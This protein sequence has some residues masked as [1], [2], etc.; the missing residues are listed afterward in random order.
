MSLATRMRPSA[1]TMAPEVTET[2]MAALLDLMRK[3]RLEGRHLEIGTAAGGTLKSLMQAY[4][5]GARPPF[6]VIDPMTYFPNQMETVHQNLRQAGIDPSCVEFRIGA[7]A[8]LLPAA[9][10]AGDRFDFVFI[11]G[12]HKAGYVIRDLGWGSLVRTGGV[13]C[14]HDHSEGHPGVTW[15]A[16]RFLRRNRGVYEK[17]AL[18]QSLLVIRKVR[19]SVG[20]EVG[21]LDRLLGDV[22]SFLHG[23][24]RSFGKRVA[25]LRGKRK[26]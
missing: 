20:D 17:V 25:A 24:R 9:K 18:V 22:M 14:M 11:D 23:L 13:I 7:S 26:G 4:P 15:A 21:G 3:E 6:S 12:N 16:S 19:D 2:E 1:L 10:A 5:E 8:E